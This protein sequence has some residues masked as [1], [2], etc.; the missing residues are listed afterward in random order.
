[1]AGI[2]LATV[3]GEEHQMDAAHVKSAA[4]AQD[5][6]AMLPTPHSDEGI[7]IEACSP[8]DHFVVE[9]QNSVYDLVVVSPKDGDV[10][11]RGGRL[12]PDFRQAQLV[13]ATA[14]GHTI[15]LLGIHVGLRL[16]LLVDR[17]SVVTSRVRSVYRA[18]LAQIQESPHHV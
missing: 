10:L 11:V 18:A 9:T 1:M 14:G 15:K 7:Q 16:E 13:G 4:H 3:S 8:L 2:T 12:F 5:I 17:R 6:G